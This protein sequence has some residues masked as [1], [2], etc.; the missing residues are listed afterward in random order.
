MKKV[1]LLATLLLSMIGAKAQ[2]HNFDSLVC[3]Y[4]AGT[5]NVALT[6]KATRPDML[7]WQIDIS[8]DSLFSTDT[9]LSSESGTGTITR[10][11]TFASTFSDIAYYRIISQSFD[12]TLGWVNDTSIFCVMAK[13]P[14]I[15]ATVDTGGV[16]LY[17]TLHVYGGNPNNVPV[18]VE[19]S[20]DS[21][22]TVST[23]GTYSTSGLDTMTFSNV[24]T[25]LS[26]CTKY[27]MRFTVNNQVF[28]PVSI[29]QS[30]KTTCTT[31]T[32]TASLIATSAVNNCNLHVN[33]QFYYSNAPDDT[34][35]IMS[36][37][38]RTSDS[39]MITEYEFDNMA[40]SGY[41]DTGYTV[42]TAGNYYCVLWAF[43]RH[44]VWLTSITLLVNVA[45]P[46]SV[47]NVA[48]QENPEG[49]VQLV[50]MDG[51]VFGPY[52]YLYK[53]L[54]KISFMPNL[55]TGDYGLRF[56]STDGTFI[57]SQKIFV[58]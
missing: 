4:N 9:L 26:L 25:G 18:L 3:M 49:S 7:I 51:K 35:T 44:G 50:S 48:I 11:E 42:P 37:I 47:S 20:T 1:F 21:F 10:T 14:M 8:H 22:A 55:P 30:A 27:Y 41:V 15:F 2:S 36:Q 43:G 54:Y 28:A 56:I 12:T 57:H 40:G 38:F 24:V 53:D 45:N 46:S 39:F 31:T 13:Q 19:F 58:H 34:L 29:E 17:W 23:V 16:N 5:G 6:Y 52:N 32:G 33:Y